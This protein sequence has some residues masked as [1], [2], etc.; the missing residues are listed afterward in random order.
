M[1]A[2]LGNYEP[3]Q[4]E[5]K[6]LEIWQENQNFEIKSPIDASFAIALP[7]P[8]VTGELH[9]GHALNDTLQDILIRYSRMQNGSAHW[10]IGCD[11]A[12]IGTQIVVEKQLAKEGKNKYDLGRPEF[13]KLVWDWTN[14]HRG[15]IEDQMKLL[16]CSPDWSKSAFTLNPNYVQAVRKAFFEFFKE[17]LIY[18][19]KRLINWCPN[20]LTSLSDLEVV[21]EDRDGKLYKIKYALVEPIGQI[22]E[23]IICTSRPET[24]FGDVAIAINPEDDHYKPLIELIQKGQNVMV[25]LPLTNKQIPIILSKTVE[26]GFGTGA[27]KITPAH[28]FN[29][30]LIAKQC[31][32]FDLENL[33]I[34]SE[35][36]EIL[37]L[38]FIPA[39]IHQ[40]ERFKA[41][42][43]TLKMLTEQGLLIE[44][45][46][47][48]QPAALHD[49]CGTVI[50]PYL[51]EQWFL[52]MESLAQVA[53]EALESGKI[54]F[55]PAR[56]GKTYLDWL[57]NIQDW[58]ISRQLWWGHTIPVYS[59]QINPEKLILDEEALH[60]ELMNELREITKNLNY[61]LEV[62]GDR[63][64]PSLIMGKKA[65]NEYIFERTAT[66]AQ[67]VL[68]QADQAFEEQLQKFNY[69]PETDVLDTWFS[70]ALWPFAAQNWPQV[71]N[72]NK[73]SWTNVLI[74]AREII[75]LWV[76]RMVFTSLKLTDKLPFTDILIHPVIQTPDGK[77]MSKSKGNAIDPIELINKYGADA[78]RLWYCSAG[79]FANQDLRFP[80][81]KEKDGTW[82]SPEIEN[83]K[84]FVNKLWNAVKF[85]L[86]HSD[87]QS[88]DLWQTNK[89]TSEIISLNQKNI[90][91]IWILN[92]WNCALKEA[93][94]H[95][96]NY[97]FAEYAKTLEDFV[98]DDFCDWYLE[99]AKINLSSQ[100]DESKTE[101]RQILFYI[102]EQALRALHPIM[103]FATEE[104]GTALTQEQTGLS[105][106]KYPTE[107]EL[108]AEIKNISNNALE[109][110][111]NGKQ[112]V[113]AIRSVRQK[114]LG[115]APNYSLNCLF[116]G[117]NEEAWYK[118][119][120]S[121]K[122]AQLA[123]DNTLQIIKKT[124]ANNLK[125]IIE[126]PAEVDLK[127]RQNV[128][129]KDLN[130]KLTEQT[131]M[132][133]RDNN[134]GFL[135]K[136]SEEAK[137][138]LKQNIKLTENEIA[139]IKEAL[140]QISQLDKIS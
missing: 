104:L 14:K 135:Q 41:R 29:D 87:S 74:T 66:G 139:E 69:I 72:I 140:L 92:A 18:R 34:F 9:M 102:L 123:Q 89:T 52:Y 116:E 132:K 105:K 19:G 98:W 106:Q 24:L 4:V 70:S 93:K 117:L 27:L 33:N 133:A 10:Q 44:E 63:R 43:E 15:K 80:G 122:K 95:L 108:D 101:I 73:P 86:H 82:V 136:A 121:Q 42:E 119:G 114:T 83:K 88:Q 127:A 120:R 75:N 113:Q 94:E 137:E 61:S 26:I 23:L 32:E 84:R 99:I 62:K 71:N 90:A 28:D 128:L 13:E 55:Y 50:E 35:K 96:Q 5:S 115:L 40:L 20:C 111:E 58:C 3:A 37:P 38:D 53:I 8:N 81:R 76:S 16:G 78:S 112:I 103:P 118:L 77:R 22:D 30:Q 64:R 7:P 1:N 126:V 134:A 39:N 85:A 109:Q 59:K 17:G 107:E 45:E 131:A 25:C 65:D 79:I 36:A 60:L 130:K 2:N 12:G 91:N 110:I 138:E 56:Y 49:R 54:K 129:E 47:Y 6:W 51:S 124:F 48:K 125:V 67:I 68:L 21:H 57:N 46:K 97:R 31:Q 100:S 11:H